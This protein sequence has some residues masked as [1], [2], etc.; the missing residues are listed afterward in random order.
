[1]LIKSDGHANVVRY[2]VKEEVNDFIYLGLQLCV[3]S[4]K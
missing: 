4:I 1:M 2:F 3:M